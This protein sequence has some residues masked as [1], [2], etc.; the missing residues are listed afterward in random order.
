MAGGEEEEELAEQKLCIPLFRV[1][2]LGSLRSTIH[3]LLFSRVLTIY[4]YEGSEKIL[5]GV[6]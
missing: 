2:F 6:Q 4:H 5:Q 3:S 1:G